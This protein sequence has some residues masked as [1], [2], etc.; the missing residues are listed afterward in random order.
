MRLGYV[1]LSLVLAA[2]IASTPQA[3]ER[4]ILAQAPAGKSAAPATGYKLSPEEL[5]L[6]C[7]KL[8]GRIR[9]GLETMKSD[10][11]RVPA[12]IVARGAQSVTTP[13][14]GGTRRG[15]DPAADLRADRARLDAY[16]A[17]LAEKKCRTI[18]IDAELKGAV[19][20]PKVA[21]RAG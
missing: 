17:R 1:S 11:T 10:M 8:T 13:F 4:L 15:A 21:P 20:A 19:P 2:A 12:S 14:L 3:G 7:P 9:V 6:D 18:D 5:K 16:N